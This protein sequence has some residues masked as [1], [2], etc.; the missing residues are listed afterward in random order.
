MFSVVYSF[1]V[2]GFT[3]DLL[4]PNQLAPRSNLLTEQDVTETAAPVCTR[5]CTGEGENVNG[6][7]GDGGPSGQGGSGEEMSDPLAAVA[8]LIGSLSS[9]DRQRLAAMLVEPPSGE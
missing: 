3:N 6:R 5:V 8:T 4:V 9:A 1:G 7:T 2:T